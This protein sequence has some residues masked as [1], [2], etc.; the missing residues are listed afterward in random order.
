MQKDKRKGLLSVDSKPFYRIGRRLIELFGLLI[1]RL[2]SGLHHEEAGDAQQDH[3]HG[4][5][6]QVG[7]CAAAQE[8]AQRGDQVAPSAT[9]IN[10]KMVVAYFLP[11]V[12]SAA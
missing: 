12:A 7:A 8:I 10:A 5:G 6:R 2:V 4:S 9:E 1:Y 11:S 3:H